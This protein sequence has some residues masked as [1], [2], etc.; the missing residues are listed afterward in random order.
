M[1]IIRRFF[2]AKKSTGPDT[3]KTNPS[4]RKSVSPDTQPVRPPMPEIT[5]P[6]VTPTFAVQTPV[7][8]PPP[9]EVR[10]IHSNDDPTPGRLES[11][12]LA[13]GSRQLPPLETVEAAIA[14]SG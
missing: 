11:I 4:S 2:G 9:K 6:D 13:S 12:A 10:E 8:Q 5:P 1:D 14:K 7:I 3:D